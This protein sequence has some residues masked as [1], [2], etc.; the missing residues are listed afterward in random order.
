MSIPE[1]RRRLDEL[2]GWL[3]YEEGETLYR[4]AKECTGRGVIVE[5]GSWRGKSTTCLALGSMAGNGVR[6]YAVDRHQPGTFADWERNVE[7]AGIADL[8]TPI[9]GLSQELAAGFDEPIELLFIDGAHEYELVKQD[10]DR[11]VPKVVDDGVVALHDTTT[12]EG[13]KRV[14]EDDV[15]KSHRFRDV[16]FV[17]GTTTVGKKVEENTA[18]DRVRNRFS[19]GVMRTVELARR[20]SAQTWLPAPVQRAGRGA[21]R[22]LP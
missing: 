18:L 14:A 2:P 7:S 4:L 21:L 5:I 3:S 13:V 15:Y 9:K 20:A 22:R 1:L 11:W 16:R 19:L 8:V 12:F 10:F 17:F 6:V